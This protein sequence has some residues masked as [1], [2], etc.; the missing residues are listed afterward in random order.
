MALTKLTAL[1]GIVPNS[2]R[3]GERLIAAAGGFLA[4]LA[5]IRIT[6]YYLPSGSGAP[7]IVASMGASSVLLF[8][9]PGSPFSQPW[10]LLAGHLIPAAIGVSCAMLIPDLP[11]ASAVTVSATILAMHYLRCIHPPG[12]ATAL[13]AVIGG[14]DIHALGYQFLITPV[15]INVLVMLG[16]AILVNYWFPGRRYPAVLNAK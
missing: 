16:M 6:G 5:A 3:H 12:C 11:V 9:V 7:L 15:G 8:I 1:L 10:P 13:T 4:I 2:A 14:G